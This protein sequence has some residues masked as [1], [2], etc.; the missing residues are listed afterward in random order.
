MQRRRN[1]KAMK[2][3]YTEG[4]IVEPKQITDKQLTIRYVVQ[5]VAMV[6]AWFVAMWICDQLLV[7]VPV[8]SLEYPLFLG[9]FDISGFSNFAASIYQ[10]LGF[11]MAQGKPY[12]LQML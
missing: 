3:R 5:I 7:I 11:P 8:G 12:L 1:K 2:A 9:N 4:V 10:A 6:L